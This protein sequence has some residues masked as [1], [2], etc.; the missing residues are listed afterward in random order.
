MRV[1]VTGCKGQ[2]GFD[3]VRELKERGFKDVIAADVDD[4][5]ITNETEVNGFVLKC[6]PDVIMHNAA[7]T[8]VDNAEKNKDVAYNVN[9][10]GC[11][12]LAKAAEKIG[13]KLVYISTDYV[14]P[15]NGNNFYEVGDRPSPINYYG[16]T[17]LE[18]EN[19]AK[20]CSKHFI[21]RTS[22]VFGINGGN[23]VKMMLNLGKT[24]NELSIVC[25]QIGSP[26]YTKD[27][28]KLLCDIIETEKYGTYHA[29]NEEVCSWA[30]F[31]IEIF[32]KSNMNVVVKPI[33]TTEYLK[34]K[35][36]QAIRPLNS[37]LSKKSLD[38]AG[39]KRLPSWQDALDR[40]L[41]EIKT[42]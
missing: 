5:D 9:V 15:G 25:D 36:I 17:K 16:K 28:A 8:A 19:A 2:L 22:W 3:C 1:L 37:R 39:F 10:L 35:P 7:Y 33:T 42:L 12:Y 26:T 30:E 32:K 14:F 38:D 23:F 24:H 41:K 13:A 34:N 4:L 11:L 31:A 21:V 18:G 20:K 29:T 27:L 40:Y 6:K